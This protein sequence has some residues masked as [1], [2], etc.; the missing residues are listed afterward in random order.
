MNK[1][2]KK[3]SNPIVLII[4]LLLILFPGRS[5][6]NNIKL[7]KEFNNKIDGLEYNGDIHYSNNINKN[8]ITIEIPENFDDKSSRKTYFIDKKGTGEGTGKICSLMIDS[9]ANYKNAEHLSQGIARFN[10]TE[11]EKVNINGTTW[12][13]TK[14]ERTP[15]EH[16]YLLEYDNKI[17]II[18]TQFT[19]EECEKELLDIVQTVK[20]Q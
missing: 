15:S 14:R 6:L 7:N 5:A 12:Y 13:H 19:S 4:I 9:V 2:T 1:T 10:G 8:K 20:V 17:I 3:N 18:E 11:S 16:N